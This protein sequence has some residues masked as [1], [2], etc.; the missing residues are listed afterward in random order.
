MAHIEI[1]GTVQADE[2]AFIDCL[3]SGKVFVD[4]NCIFR[5]GVLLLPYGGSIHL[6]Q[7]VSVGAYSVLYGHGGLHIGCDT[8][9]GPQVVIIPA[10]HATESFDLPIR[11]QGETRRGINIGSNIWIGAGAKI[12]DGVVIED[13]AVVA[14]GAVVT[15]RVPA[16]AIVGGVPARI[17]KMRTDVPDLRLY[18]CYADVER[19]YRRERRLY[20]EFM[21]AICSVTAEDF[22]LSEDEERALPGDARYQASGWFHRMLARY[23]FAGS[24]FCR[25]QNVLDVCSGLGW[26]GHIL[27]RYAHSVTCLERDITV[28]SKAANFWN[29][30][31]I[32]WKNCDALALDT[33]LPPASFDVVTAMEAIEHFNVEDGYCLVQ[34]IHNALKKGGYLVAS[35]IFPDSREE[36][37]ALCAK[38]PF[39]LY[40]YTEKEILSFCAALFS[41]AKIIDNMLLICRK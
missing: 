39:H 22:G 40:I 11:L 35:S 18:E 17:L 12:L 28:I 36:A 21:H 30:P 24:V 32:I 31:K 15:E 6:A 4:D 16:N 23:F 5:H 14:A 9:I 7:N 1:K 13:G 20:S 29:N 25:Q 41:E 37:Q 8:L 3:Y 26:G 38:N 34:Q 27:T 19:V 2:T 10:N 33:H